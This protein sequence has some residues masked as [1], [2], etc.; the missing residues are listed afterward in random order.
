MVKA[1]QKKQLQVRDTFID[2]AM[3]LSMPCLFLGYNIL[4]TP[5]CDLHKKENDYSKLPF[6]IFTDIIIK[7]TSMWIYTRENLKTLM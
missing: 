3:K 4:T 1:V 2:Q 7:S 6:K 5:L